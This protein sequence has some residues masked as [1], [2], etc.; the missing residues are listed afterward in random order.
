MQ[1]IT[2][3]AVRQERLDQM[4]RR[5]TALLVVAA[6]V[7]VVALML[8]RRSASPFWWGALR[9][10]AEAAV[11]GGL[12]DWFAVTAL[13]RHPLGIPI[14]HTAIVATRKD[15]VGRSLGG[16]VQRHFLAR[17]V[18]ETRLRSFGAAE[19]LAEWLADPA[20]ARTIAR[21][22]AAGLAQGARLVPEADAERMIG[23]T[24]ARHVGKIPVAPAL[25][26]LLD[27][28]IAHDR[29]QRLLSEALRLGTRALDENRLAIRE[30]IGEETPWWLPGSVDEKIARKVL[31]GIERAAVEIERDPAH[32]V[33]V[34]FDTALRDFVAR[35]D[36][37]P[38]TAQQV[39]AWKNEVLTTEG[40]KRL[41]ATLWQ[42][43]VA[44]LER[45]ADTSGGDSEGLVAMEQAIVALATRVRDDA[46]LLAQIEAGIVDVVTA[47]VDRHQAEV[48]DL[49]ASTVASWDARETSRRVELAIG[50]D[51]QYIRING[52]LVGG[53]A[54]L[55][56][57]F[58]TQLW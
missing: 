35:L 4:K 56:L 15:R 2:D 5:A 46:V 47:M 26:R 55:V 25:G 23:D 10:T 22:A 52:T 8:E 12:A 33:R 48:G 50:R 51:L 49:I 45:V 42:N 58:L 57:Y 53:L 16:F 31:A 29:H 9:Y 36:T 7:F 40:A 54:G 32:P 1:P 18:I 39:E 43:G 13:F 30:R 3:E 28:L 27:S 38:E 14:P 11:V 41:S 44:A 37:S 21:Q 6:I 24:I 20:H 19:R 17:E 34:R